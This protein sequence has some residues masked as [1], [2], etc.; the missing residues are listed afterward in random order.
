MTSQVEFGLGCVRARV[1]RLYVLYNLPSLEFLDFTAIS[2]TERRAASLKGSFLHVVRPRDEIL[3]S[4][5]L[6]VYTNLNPMYG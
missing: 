5:Q 1:R 3:H 4:I 6:A 2:D